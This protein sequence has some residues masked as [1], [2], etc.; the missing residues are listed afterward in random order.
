MT[1]YGA[2][3]SS[4]YTG[5]FSYDLSIY[6][7]KDADFEIPV[8]LG[9]HFDGFR[10]MT[11]SGSIGYG[12]YLNA[13]GAITREV[14]GVQDEHKASEC[15]SGDDCSGYYYFKNTGRATTDD[16]VSIHS[17]LFSGGSVQ[18]DQAIPAY[19]YG[20]RPEYIYK[21]G[22]WIKTS[23]GDYS[24]YETTPDI[25]HFS[26]GGRQGDFIITGANGQC[27]A[28][29][30]DGA[31]GEY[32]IRLYPSANPSTGYNTEIVIRD[33]KGYIYTYGGGLDYVD[34]TDWASRDA[35][36]SKSILYSYFADGSR[37]SALKADGSGLVYRG[38]FVFSRGS[39]REEI[40]E[41]IGS[42][43]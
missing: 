15:V 34:Y 7:Y 4:M 37:Y 21:D 40:I 33:G 26:L 17:G 22:N 31:F 20:S 3:H 2:V 36:E 23:I 6:T 5:A 8:S 38:S 35:G 10:P 16:V 25:F 28:Y 27:S 19:L 11:G 30:C 24:N 14:R 39:G 13:G 18:L 12:W 42:C 43:D 1:K 29:S 32:D 41:S 9:Y